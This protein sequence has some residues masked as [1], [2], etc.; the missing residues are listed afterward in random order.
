MKFVIVLVAI[1]GLSAVVGA[2]VIGSMVFEGTVEDHP[3]ERG[4]IW[5]G[6]RRAREEAGISVTIESGKPRTGEEDIT[7]AVRDSRGAPIKD[8]IL[9]M[10]LVRPASAAY[11]SAVEVAPMGGG[12][13]RAHLSIALP[14]LWELRT[15]IDRGDISVDIPVRF[16]AV[17]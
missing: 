6:T 14:G 12:L 7:V 1:V 10:T 3:Y 17:E 8:A 5:D 13:Y 15:V 11:D 4:L 2:V 9:H 16:R